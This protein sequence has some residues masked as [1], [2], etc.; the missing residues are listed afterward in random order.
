MP[1]LNVREAAVRS[2][3]IRVRSYDVHLD[4]TVGDQQF[5]SR[6]VIE[7]ESLDHQSTFVDIRPAVLHDV[8][9]NQLRLDPGQ[10]RDGRFHLSDLRDTNV[11]VM[12]ATMDYSH[13]GE[14][15]HRSVD[16]EDKLAYTYA[17]CFLDAAPRIFA[18]FDQ[19]DLKATYRLNVTTPDDWTVVGNGAAIQSAPG[20]W[21]LTETKPLST[22]FVTLV[23]GP[24]HSVTRDHDGISLGLHCR[25]SLAPYLDRDLEELFDVT[26]QCF[27]EFHRLFGIRYPFGEYHQAFV[28]EFNA[29]AMENA[30]C[31]TLRDDLVFR[32]PATDSLR[33]TRA[34]V[35]AHEMAHQWF[36]DLVTMR[37]WDDLWLNESFAE[38]MG[39]RATA[40]AT[41]FNDVWVEFGL[42]RKPWGMAADQRSSTHPVAGNGAA[43]A[44][45]ALHD[46][47]GISYSKGA[48]ALRQLNAFLGDEAFIGGVVDHLTRHSYGNATLADLL[49]SWERA[50]GK[51]VSAWGAAWLRTSGIDT[52]ACQLSDQREAVITRHNGS[53]DDV[54]RPHAI[55]VHSYLGDGSFDAA[56]VVVTG[57]EARV[58]L[59]SYDG[60]PFVLPDAKDETWAKIELDSQTLS[61]ATEIL[62]RLKEP[63]P[64]V[65][66]WGA[67]RESLLDGIMAPDAYL[68]V[69]EAAIPGEIDEIVEFVF[70][71]ACNQWLGTYLVQPDAR[72]RLAAVAHA[73]VETAP[74]GSNRQ[75]IAVRLQ[76]DLAEE[77]DLLNR[78]LDGH[79]PAG[80]T[81]DDDFT[82]R[83][84]RALCELGAADEDRV[85]LQRQHDP[86]SQGLLHAHKCRA[87]MPTAE[88]KRQVWRCLVD[89]E[90][91]SNWEAYA[92]AEQFFRRSQVGL[93][94]PYV[95][96]YFTEFAAAAGRRG[97]MMAEG[98]ALLAFPR[99]AVNPE[100]V[101][102]AEA[103][104]A[105]DLDP[106][107]RR[108]IADCRDDM[109]RLLASRAR[110][111]G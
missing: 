47:D 48:S 21:S 106:G 71:R 22:Y 56:S 25:Q 63:V 8:H 61:R 104:L 101:T 108:M 52:L 24:Y 12:D 57:S 59:P 98:L 45:T 64:R 40:D 69:L 14:G 10:L 105:G 103:A 23:A 87:S 9:L 31:I 38:Y 75:L 11:L 100:T 16:P 54:D 33:A 37:W 30:G 89:D 49:D 93:T 67:L 65:V 29:G 102:R 82:W 51:D 97:G 58:A 4:L 1:S 84:L 39:Y 19:P 17:M 27:D 107:V 36:G 83:V 85:A 20:E 90:T 96:R 35:V 92:L 42:V 3:S 79:G 6:T 55:T 5:R 2:R 53:S 60:Q 70:G 26:G 110:L 13:D 50:S 109:Q 44:Q 91:L 72:F 74:P 88:T 81:V 86:S 99:Y 68:Q 80:L 46:F 7:F 94:Q 77:V 66:M 32:A 78:W 62:T 34:V 41:R 28:P 76:I 18:C 73:L 95:E 43:D 111:S 15:L